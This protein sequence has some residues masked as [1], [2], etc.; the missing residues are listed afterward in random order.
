[1]E[2]SISEIIKTAIELDEL[3]I[4]NYLIEQQDESSDS[5]QIFYWKLKSI[6]DFP[7]AR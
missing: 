6:V 3:L 5:P 7:S 2:S 1:M 4:E